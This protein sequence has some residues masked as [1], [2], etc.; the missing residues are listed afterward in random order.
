MRTYRTALIIA[1]LSATGLAL[2]ACSAPSGSDVPA[3][4]SGLAG[5]QAEYDAAV[6]DFPYA[7]PAD[8]KF[9]LKVQKPAESTLY[10]K[11]SGLGKAYQFWECSWQQTAIDAQGKQAEAVTEALKQLQ[12]GLSSAYRTQYV[13]D[14]DG[15]WKKAL[16]QAQLGDL[17]AVSDFY[18]SDCVW[19][20]AEMKH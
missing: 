5:V 15:V 18:N 7:L 3:G 4:F 17:S 20:R 13:I 10:Q 1:V 8:I 2:A 9:P 11:G 14:S 19:Y 16:E 6:H 12:G